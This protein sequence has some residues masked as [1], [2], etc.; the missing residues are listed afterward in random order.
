[1]YLDYENIPPGLIKVGS[2]D[3]VKPKHEPQHYQIE[4]CLIRVFD[5][6]VLHYSRVHAETGEVNL[7]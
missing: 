4:G 1:M 2:V 3:Y 6:L 7:H 5:G